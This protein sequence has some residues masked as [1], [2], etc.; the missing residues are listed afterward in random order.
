MTRGTRRRRHGGWTRRGAY[1]FNTLPSTPAELAAHA[2]LAAAYTRRE[3]ATIV[4]P[5][6]DALKALLDERRKRE[7][8]VH[9]AEQE[10]RLAD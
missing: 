8:A 6:A 7:E 9:N 10:R 2:A 5:L 1:S 3:P 4:K